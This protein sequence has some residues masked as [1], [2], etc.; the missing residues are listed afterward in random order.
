MSGGASATPDTGAAETVEAALRM[1]QPGA[2]VATGPAGEA[3]ANGLRPAQGDDGAADG[4]LGVAAA[5]RNP[6]RGSGSY[7]GGY[8]LKGAPVACGP[9]KALLRTRLPAR[10]EVANLISKV[11]RSAGYTDVAGLQNGAGPGGNGQRVK[12]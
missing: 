1:V 6:G 9:V 5:D 4:A 8:G 11:A 3:G 12:L 7:G 2:T 10:Q